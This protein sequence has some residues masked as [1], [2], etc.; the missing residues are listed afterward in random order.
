[1][2]RLSKG[3]PLFALGYPAGNSLTCTSGHFLGYQQKPV[4]RIW[5][6]VPILEG[7][8]GGA[9]VTHEGKLMGINKEALLGTELGESGIVYISIPANL[10]ENWAK[11]TISEDK[12]N[13]KAS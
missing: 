2:D 5:S 12:K 13:S 10:L 7:N 8:S 3:T 4:G 6:T 9:I 1:L 11:S